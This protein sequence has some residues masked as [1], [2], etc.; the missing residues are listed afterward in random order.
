MRWLMRLAL[1]L[2]AVVIGVLLVGSGLPVE[3]RATVDRVVPGTPAQVWDVLTAVEDFPRWRPEVDGVVRLEDRN[4][5]PAWREEGPSGV[6]NLGAVWYEPP[7]RMV[8][9]VSDED[10]AFGG[11]WTYD[12]SPAESEGTRITITEVGEVY[13]PFFRFMARYVFGHERSMRTYLEALE[14]RMSA[15]DTVGG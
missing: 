5:L 12:L 1:V 7:D 15:V 6:L 13:S 14:A 10:G 2:L 11:S 3:H 9:R 4:G 8:V